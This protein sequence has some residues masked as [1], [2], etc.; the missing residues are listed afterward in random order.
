MPSLNDPHHEA[1]A[2]GVAKGL[3]FSKA[4]QGVYRDCSPKSARTAGPRLM[5]DVAVQRRVE[6]LQ[7]KAANRA[8]ATIESLGAEI[9]TATMAAASDGAHAAVMSGL[10]L[11][12]QLYGLIDR[13]QVG[14]QTQLNV[15]VLQER[16]AALSD[17]QRAHLK[18]LAL[19][20]RGNTPGAS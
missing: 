20:L 17:E 15:L 1:F 7:T 9:D 12:G 4:Y 5:G 19:V 3:S 2:Q 8:M 13:K 10:K 14:N 11:K 18:Q 6:E 16:I